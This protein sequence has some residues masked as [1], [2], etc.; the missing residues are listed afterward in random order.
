M[1]KR[2][3]YI[4]F[5]L[6]EDTDETDILAQVREELEGLRMFVD[7]GEASIEASETEDKDLSLIHI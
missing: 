2:Q 3:A 6:E 5:Y 1:Y 4:S 7:I